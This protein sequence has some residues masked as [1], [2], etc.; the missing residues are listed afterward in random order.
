MTGAHHCGCETFLFHFFIYIKKRL[1]GIKN[2]TWMTMESRQTSGK[3]MT[4]IK[5]Q[6]YDKNAT[7]KTMWMSLKCKK[8]NKTKPGPKQC[9]ESKIPYYDWICDGV[10]N[11]DAGS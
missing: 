11:A 6:K 3:E 1:N 7:E 8:G 4:I 2:K 10:E 5:Q 9:S